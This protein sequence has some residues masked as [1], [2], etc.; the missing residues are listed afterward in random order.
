MR[1][2]VS[3][4]QARN[5]LVAL[6]A[7]VGELT[8][9]VDRAERALSNIASDRDAQREHQMI[10]EWRTDMH[11]AHEVIAQLHQQYPHTHAPWTACDEQHRQP[12]VSTV[13]ELKQPR[14]RAGR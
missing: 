2:D 8:Y 1:D 7:Y 3:A 13:T 14:R 10:T 4:A 5:F 9:K 12:P 6:Y 11:A